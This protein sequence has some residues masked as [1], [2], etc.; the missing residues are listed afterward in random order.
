MML[1]TAP[2]SAVAGATDEGGLVWRIVA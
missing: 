2:L 1:K